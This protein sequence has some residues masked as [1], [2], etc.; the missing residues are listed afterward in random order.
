MCFVSCY[1]ISTSAQY[2]TLDNEIKCLSLPFFFFLGNPTDKT[3]TGT[4]Y[5]GKL[6]DL[7][8]GV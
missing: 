3:V 1:S 5:T 8:L 6:S 7:I 2:V 4:A